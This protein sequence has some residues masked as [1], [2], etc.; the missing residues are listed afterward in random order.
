MVGWMISCWVRRLVGLLNCW[1]DD[2]SVVDELV[3][4]IMVGWISRCVV[5][6]YAD[7]WLDNWLVG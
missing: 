1:L 4:I 2:C 5:D 3:Y 6:F 7:E